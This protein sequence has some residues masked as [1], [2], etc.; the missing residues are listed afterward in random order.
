[1]F[2]KLKKYLWVFPLIWMGVIFI[3]SHQPGK[4]SAE[5]SGGITQLII[6]FFEAVNL[7][8]DGVRL[9]NMVR[10][11]AHFTIFFI[12]GQLWYIALR[13]RNISTS[14][15]AVMAFGICF[16]YAMFDEGH[17]FFIPGRA[18][19]MKD[20]MVDSA[21]AGI[22]IIIAWLIPEWKKKAVI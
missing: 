20:V 11:L 16:G 18:C 8:L 12:L 13:A 7:E 15:A 4:D 22:A 1:M 5:L 14:R 21:G 2:D 19:D 17:Q 10:V 6:N 3:F 9:H